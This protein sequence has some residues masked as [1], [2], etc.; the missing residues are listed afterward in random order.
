MRLNQFTILVWI[1]LVCCLFTSCR[2]K[3]KE[4]EAMRIQVQNLIA[5]IQDISHL[6]T[7]DYRILKVVKYKDGIPLFKRSIYYQAEFRVIG[8]INLKAIQ[9]INTDVKNKRVRIQLPK[10]NPPKISMIPIE[11]SRIRVRRSL[12][13]NRFTVEEIGILNGKALKSVQED[14]HTMSL[15]ED[16]ISNAKIV[17]RNLFRNIGFQ[18]DFEI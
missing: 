5:E 3:E 15:D 6:N 4:A 12:F 13:R 10:P 11:R 9:L 7:I 16:V 17:I 18:V 1:S 14:L 2:Q 8:S